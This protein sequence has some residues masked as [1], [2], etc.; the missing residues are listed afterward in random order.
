MKQNRTVNQLSRLQPQ[1][2]L[3]I[4]IKTKK[5]SENEFRGLDFL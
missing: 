1:A 4:K 2:L 3:K 5:A